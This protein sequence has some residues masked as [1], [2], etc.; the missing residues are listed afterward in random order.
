MSKWKAEEVGPAR[1]GRQA[2][3]KL[4]EKRQLRA[5]A[6]NLSPLLDS[7]EQRGEKALI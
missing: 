7:N 2:G 3:M 1:R 4:L 6:R 5:E